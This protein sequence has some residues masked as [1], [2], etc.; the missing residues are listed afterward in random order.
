MPGGP[1]L[2]R[3]HPPSSPP[4]GKAQ[5][6]VICLSNVKSLQSQHIEAEK[7]STLIGTA[8][9][10]LACL[11]EGKNNNKELVQR[12][13]IGHGHKFTRGE[14][15]VVCEPAVHLHNALNQCQTCRVHQHSDRD[16]ATS[17]LTI[18]PGSMTKHLLVARDMSA[19]SSDPL[20]DTTT[21][22]SQAGMYDAHAYAFLTTSK[23]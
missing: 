20:H 6:T 21:L 12:G 19:G 2:K 18:S 13:T 7:T 8:F 3:L 23:S 1:F 14:A 11:V 9:A 17:L 22:L 10:A 4:C 5:L 15:P 16:E